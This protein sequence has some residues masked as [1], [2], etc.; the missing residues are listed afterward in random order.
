[1]A[2]RFSFV[3]HCFDGQTYSNVSN[4]AFYVLGAVLREPGVG[5]Y[6]APYFVHSGDVYLAGEAT[7]ATLSA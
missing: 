4:A 2:S 7:A 1:M 3:G 6:R 5:S